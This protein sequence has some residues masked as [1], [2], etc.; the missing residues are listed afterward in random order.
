[1]FAVMAYVWIYKE[2]TSASATMALRLL[3]TR[4]CAWVRRKTLFPG[5]V[6]ELRLQKRLPFGHPPQVT[7]LSLSGTV[8][9]K[10]ELCE[11][12]YGFSQCKIC[13]QDTPQYVLGFSGNSFLPQMAFTCLLTWAFRQCYMEIAML[14]A[15]H[16]P[17]F[18]PTQG[19]SQVVLVVKNPP[20]NAGAIR[21]AGLIPG[22]GRSPGG[23]VWQP[24][25]VFLPGESPWTEEPGRPQSIGSQR[26]GHDSRDLAHRHSSTQKSLLEC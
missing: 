19:A 23:R 22:S 6:M 9:T 15:L 1:M 18:V 25:P 11:T 20:L 13:K 16:L 4:R 3:R 17:L 26:G 10:N 21:D 24:T 8:L 5:G 12:V 14:P 7:T 2:V